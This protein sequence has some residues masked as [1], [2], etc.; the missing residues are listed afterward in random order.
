MTNTQPGFR[1]YELGDYAACLALFDEHC[2]AYFAPSER[3]AYAAFLEKSADDYAVY[4]FVGKVAG[5]YGLT[6]ESKGVMS[7]R[8]IMVGRLAQRQGVGRTMMNRVLG[9]LRAL[10]AKKLEIAASQK[11]APFFAKFG[12]REI[13]TTPDGWGSGM[14]RVDMELTP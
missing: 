7:L 4:V 3:Q 14:H 12:A 5:G 1:P 6:I 10:K 9:A 13:R 2:P 8:W 11:S